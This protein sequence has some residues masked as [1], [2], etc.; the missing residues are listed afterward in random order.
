[1][2][3]GPLADYASEGVHDRFVGLGFFVI[4][5]QGK[6]LALSAVCTHKKCKLAAAKDRSFFCDCHG[7]TFDADGRV[8]E[9]PAKRNLPFLATQVND[10]GHLLVHVAH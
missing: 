10:N 3:A 5:R 1:M 8:T 9:G 4:R 6:L 2:D 7:S